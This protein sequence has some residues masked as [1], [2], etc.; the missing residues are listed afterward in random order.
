MK[1]LQRIRAVIVVAVKRLLAQ[2][3]LTLSTTLGLI[4]AITMM[5]VVPL[6]AEAVSFRVLSER[7]A[8]R[9]DQSNRPAF[10]YLFTYIGSWERPANYEEAEVVNRYLREQGVLQLGLQ[11]EQFVR[12]YE[13]TRMRLYP[14]GISNYGDDSIIDY[15]TFGTTENIE[16]YIEFL[17][18]NFP[19]PAPSDPTSPIEIAITEVFANQTGMQIGDTFTTFNN[20]LEATHSQRTIDVRIAG[21]WRALDE[22]NP[23]WFY[24]PAAFDDVMLLHPDTYVN[25]ISP[26]TEMEVN[27]GVWYI[28]TDGSGITTNQVPNLI[29]Q[30]NLVEQRVDTLLPGT[31]TTLS[32]V[33]ELVPYQRTAQRLT[34]LLTAFSIP[35]VALMIVFLTLVIGLSVEQ[36]RNETAILRS[37][38]ST[39]LQI[40]GLAIIEGTILGIVSL[41][42][43]TGLAVLITWL[44][45]S[46]RSFMNFSGVSN[47]QVVFT[48]NALIT[49]GIAILL[50]IA[51]HILP[52]LKIAR[53]TVVSYKLERA[54]VQEQPFWQRLGI[55]VLLAGVTAYFYY[56]LINEG[57]LFLSGADANSV[58][59]NFANP[60]LF[61]LPPLTIFATTLIL[62]RVLSLF[63]RLTSWILQLTN[64]VSLL[65]ATRH[66]ERTP[67]Y[68]FHPTILLV[69]T[70][71][72]GVFTASYA[73]TIDRSLFEQLYYRHTAD[74]S[75]Q[76]FVETAQG[77]V[78]TVAS[79]ALPMSDYREMDYMES[80][81]RF[82]QYDARVYQTGA[83]VDGIFMGIDRHEF[84]SISFWRHDFAD[85]RLGDLLNNLA[86][87]PDT[88]LVSRNLMEAN[89]LQIGDFI[90]VDLN[91]DGALV[92][93]TVRIAGVVDYFPRWYPETDDVLVVGNLDYIFEEAGT[94]LDYLLVARTSPGIDYSQFRLELLSRG[95]TGV[96]YN[97]P[98]TAIERGQALPERQG[99]FGLLSIGFV[100]STVVT[101]LGFFLYAF[102]SY[103]RRFIE[104]GVL[105]AVG[106]TQGE[107][108]VSV[109][110]ELGLLMVTG[111]GF[112][113]GI[114]VI[115]SRLYVPYMQIGSRAS[116]N[117]PP[118]LVNM[119]WIEITQILVLF[120]TLFVISM[121]TLI[122]VL[123][124]MR[125][126]EAVKLGETV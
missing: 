28:I 79:I 17:E 104:L 43:G 33:D 84:G 117:V 72:L 105:R 59:S 90:R 56:V 14:S 96:I 93:L 126:F 114:G 16:N 65:I 6:Y 86:I 62:L 81:T 49:G 74:L 112:G 63:M 110:W 106:L 7:L 40:I 119:A 64:N 80:V 23:Y 100:A 42:I 82:G 98:F 99:L 5:L 101:V 18:G 58:E 45:G 115:V 88:V 51:I 46:V 125:I 32:P 92:E 44:M 29:E 41:L 78:S 1:Y 87:S 39:S 31:Y 116:E 24:R 71:A 83:N 124:R 103:R 4:A 26:Y 54:R 85:Q 102:F 47:L 20:Q 52:T 38:G 34:I 11:A 113:I 21:I 108:M 55:D 109:A 48:P 50:S 121:I 15:L 36:K 8:A 60:L 76:V 19:A 30:N 22:N 61:L 70:I 73:R 12:H 75:F 57:N 25:R 77:E 53:H 37:R 27:L 91:V 123:R 10:S 69:C 66:L 95:I 13:T 67:G 122:I 118:Y 35:I 97:Q 89:A 9:N 2:P 120:L 111:L 94:D 3:M 68:Y 107:M